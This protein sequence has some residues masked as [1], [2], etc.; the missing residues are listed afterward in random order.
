[1]SSPSAA[2]T[3]RNNHESEYFACSRYHGEDHRER[4]HLD[5]GS[6]DE[7]L[8]DVTFDL[9]NNQDDREHE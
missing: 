1:M 4:V 7:G 9:L 3:G 2:H 6:H 5:R 8:Q